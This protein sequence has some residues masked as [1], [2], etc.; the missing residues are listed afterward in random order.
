[1]VNIGMR[2]GGWA[3]GGHGDYSLGRWRWFVLRDL[4]ELGSPFIFLKE[5][6]G[7]S[8]ISLVLP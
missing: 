6:Q 5:F 7:I 4:K 8:E 2:G 1:M 3:S